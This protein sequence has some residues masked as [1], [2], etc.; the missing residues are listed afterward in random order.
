MAGQTGS[1]VEV[2]KPKNRKKRK[3]T[4]Q[5]ENKEDSSAVQHILESGLDG[6]A[7]ALRIII[8]E[9]MRIERSKALQAQPYERTDQ[10]Q[11]HSN[12]F[13]DKSVATRIGKIRFS[14]PQV[15]GDVDFYPS[16]LEKG[17]RSERALKLA[18]AEMYIQGVS[19]RRVTRILEQLCGLEITSSQVSHATALLDEELEKWRRRSLHIPF[20]CLILDARYEKV[21]IDG[22]VQSCAVLVAIGVDT[23]GKRS[24]LGVSAKLSEAEVHWRDFLSSLQERGLHGVNY[25]VSD[26]HKGLRAALTTRFTG[27]PWQRCQ[28]HLQ[29]NAMAHVPKINMREEVAQD[30]RSIFN[31]PDLQHAQTRLK[32]VVQKYQSSAS[33]LASWLETNI[34][35]ALTVFSRPESERKKLCT[36]NSLERLNREIKRRTRVVSVFPNEAALERLVSALLSETNDDWDSERPFL[37]MKN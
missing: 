11:G 27:V 12:G 14:V 6:L 28:F 5:N 10:R 37:S 7:E 30:I 3:M 8:N 18:I 31:S 29:Q 35:E 2:I 17:I 32:E 33:K 19:T 20:V 22:L 9:A 23:Q 34:P 26:N 21:R 16:A 24:V 1:S 25:I 15:R 36:T 13:K 4:H